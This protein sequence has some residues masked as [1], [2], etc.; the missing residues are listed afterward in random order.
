M[1]CIVAFKHLVKGYS[2]VSYHQGNYEHVKA[3][4]ANTL[5][6]SGLMGYLYEVREVRA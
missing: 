5:A 4:I 3:K 2:R 1:A 6:D